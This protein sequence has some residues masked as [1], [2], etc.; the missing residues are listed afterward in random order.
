MFPVLMPTSFLSLRFRDPRFQRSDRRFILAAFPCRHTPFSSA[1]IP[2]AR[3]CVHRYKLLTYC[4]LTCVRGVKSKRRSCK[5]P[6][7][8]RYA[9]GPAGL[10]WP[11]VSSPGLAA[12]RMR[13]ALATSKTAYST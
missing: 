6:I 9:Q 13:T 7:C 1:T 2:H 5:V 4:R 3:Y 8:M 12:G 11:R 10:P